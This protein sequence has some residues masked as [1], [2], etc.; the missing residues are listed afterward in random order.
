[1]AFPGRHA[2]PCLHDFIVDRVV[3]LILH[4]PIRSPASSHFVITGRN[5]VGKSTICDAVEFAILGELSKYNVESA[6]KETVKD[7]V[8]WRGDGVPE[9]YY[10]TAGFS[11]SEGKP[12]SVTRTREGGSDKTEAELATVLCKDAMPSD[13][14]RQ[15]CR[16]TIIRDEWI[17]ALSLE[18]TE[19]QRFDLV[20][21]ALGSI[22]GA[23][24]ISKAAAVVKAAEAACGRVE[25]SYEQARLELSGGLSQLSEANAA[26]A[27]AADVSAAMEVVD[28]EMSPDTGDLAQR[29]DALRRDLPNRQR[30]LAGMNETAFQ[31]RELIAYRQNHHS[32]EAT[33]KREQLRVRLLTARETEVAAQSEIERAEAVY[34]IQAAADEIAASLSVLVA[35]GAALG[36]HDNQCPLCAANRSSDEFQEGIRRARERIDNLAAGVNAAREKLT[37]ARAGAVEPARFVKELEILWEIEEK[38]LAIL[39]VL[40]EAYFALFERYDL[41]RKFV[42]DLDGMEREASIE[43]DQLVEI[44]RALNA[45]DASRAVV[46]LASLD[47]RVSGFRQQVDAAADNLA[48]VQTAVTTAKSLEKSVKRSAG[49]IVDERLALINPLLNELYQRLRPLS[50]CTKL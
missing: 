29:M 18:L 8:W 32:T 41:D 17:A 38:E 20:R 49:E 6:A 10:V 7:Y 3:D 14:L 26:A 5:G 48:R 19:M 16:T 24:L 47:S 9:A 30:R 44:E 42:F 15:L 50:H 12:F 2:G 36:L 23:N 43:R 21:A 45:L 13:P 25:Q 22:D 27:R 28:R 37:A 39:Q 33:A 11:N 1:M 35:H 31:G 34:A 40:E 46:Q 4:G